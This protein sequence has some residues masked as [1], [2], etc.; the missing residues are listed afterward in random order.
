MIWSNHCCLWG[1]VR[2]L[3]HI[4]AVAREFIVAAPP[5]RTTALVRVPPAGESYPFPGRKKGGTKK[6]QWGPGREQS[7]PLVNT[8]PFR[9]KKGRPPAIKELHGG[10]IRKI[11][12][13]ILG[14]ALV[15]QKTYSLIHPGQCGKPPARPLTAPAQRKGGRGRQSLSPFFSTGVARLFSSYQMAVRA[16]SAVLP[17]GVSTIFGKRDRVVSF[18]SFRFLVFINRTESLILF[19]CFRTWRPWRLCLVIYRVFISFTPVV[20]AGAVAL[21]RATAVQ[22]E[23]DREGTP[24]ST[25]SGDPPN[26]NCLSARIDPVVQHDRAYHHRTPAPWA[27]VIPPLPFFGPLF[28]EIPREFCM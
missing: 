27:I 6:C 28:L 5:E 4:H 18:V 17:L 15:R 7:S 9:A 21:W 14:V 12:Q 24:L 23:K 16:P 10:R 8:S 3:S 26:H 25:M 20:T 19:L 2:S 1:P 11:E 13:L 22:N